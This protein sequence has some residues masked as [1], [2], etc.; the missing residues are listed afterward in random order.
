MPRAPGPFDPGAIRGDFPVLHQSVRGKPLVYLDS[1]ATSQK[2][3]QVIQALCEYYGTCNANVHRS[4]HYLGEQATQKYE[5]VRRMTAEFIGAASPREIVF[6]RGTTES[7]NLVAHSWARRALKAGDTILLTE[8]E[9]HSNIVPWQL[10]AQATGALLRYVPVLPDGTLDRD[11]C[12]R[13]L[14]PSVKLFAVTQ[15]SN[16]LG[17]VNPV[18]ELAA[19]ARAA[20]AAVLIDGAQSVP[21]G[22]VDVRSLGCDFLAFSGHKMCGPTGVGV[23]YARAERLE[24]MDPFMGGGEMIGRVDPDRSTWAEVPNKFE[25]GT[26]NIAGVIGLGAALAYLTAVGRDAMAQYD[27]ELAREAVALLR[28]TPGVR[29]FGDAPGRGGAVSFDVAGIHPHDIAQFLDQEGVAI[30]AGHLCAQLLMRKLGVPAV[31]RASFYLYNVPSE[32]EALVAAIRRA[33]RYFGHGS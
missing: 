29:V 33:Q 3:V 18:A 1:A 32:A 13:M 19:E 17:T 26:P 6:T 20:G 16:V 7:I 12:R 23:L 22:P 24:S 30:R 28:A 5:D 4:F 21:H 27:R 9:H 10:A 31:N 14:D 11:A 15:M 25:A 8:M 2:P